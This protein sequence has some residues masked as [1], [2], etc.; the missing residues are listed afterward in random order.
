MAR[1][2]A[3]RRLTDDPAD[4]YRRAQARWSLMQRLIRDPRVVTVQKDWYRQADTHELLAQWAFCTDDDVANRWCQMAAE[5][6]RTGIG[7][8][9]A[10][11]LAPH[12]IPRWLADAVSMAG[13]MIAMHAVYGPDSIGPWRHVVLTKAWATRTMRA[14]KVHTGEPAGAGIDR[15]VDWYYRARVKQPRDSIHTLA[16]AYRTRRQAAGV[17]VGSDARGLIRDGIRRA[18]HAL[19]LL[20]AE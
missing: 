13:L 19:D 3:P 9:V 20:G 4:Q 5:S 7:P 6:A 11:V 14:P 12:S 18:E 15:D 8:R 1:R 17:H 10:E 16:R 2:H